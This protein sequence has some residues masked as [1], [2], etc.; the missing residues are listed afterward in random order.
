MKV[1]ITDGNGLYVSRDDRNNLTLTTNIKLASFYKEE[2]ALNVITHNLKN[3]K[4]FSDKKWILQEV[5]EGP[6]LIADIS[7]TPEVKANPI[8]PMAKAET[9][10]ITDSPRIFKDKSESELLQM[11]YDSMEAYCELETRM[12]S[13]SQQLHEQTK[14]REDLEHAIENL[15]FSASEGYKLCK[16]IQ[17]VSRRRRTLK[18]NVTQFNMIRNEAIFPNVLKVREVLQ[19]LRDTE[20]ADTYYNR[21]AKDLGERIQFNSTAKEAG[22][23]L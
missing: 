16:K 23:K 18:K 20:S 4:F 19:K 2:K 13:L 10:D 11:I 14:L 8:V 5:A 21:V 15:R 9:V 17:D 22:I 3:M 1:I 12:G 7:E 6:V